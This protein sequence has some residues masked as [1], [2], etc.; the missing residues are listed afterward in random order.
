MAVC[1]FCGE[2]F[3]DDRPNCPHC[4]AD[5]DLTWSNDEYDPELGLPEDEEKEYQEFLRSEG[6]T[7]EPRKS[8]C[9]LLLALP[10]AVWAVLSHLI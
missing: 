4:G 9:L 10:P 7:D 1:A 5:K 3:A 2:M 8:G 6:L